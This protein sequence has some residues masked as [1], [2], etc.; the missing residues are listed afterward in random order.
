MSGDW[1]AGVT[2]GVWLAVGARELGDY[3]RSR[4]KTRKIG[5]AK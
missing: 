2:V 5:L 4:R 3:I 1:L